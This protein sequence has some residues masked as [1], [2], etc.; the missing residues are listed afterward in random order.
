[1]YDVLQGIRVI[2]LSTWTMVPSGGAVCAEWG[3]DVI[4]IEHPTGDPQRRIRF[5]P[6]WEEPAAKTMTHLPNRGKRSLALDLH[7]AR[8]RDVLLRLVAS[9]DVFLTNFLTPARQK[10]RV[11]VEHL[12]EVNPRLGY[13][14]ATGQG[15]RGPE[16]TIGG[17]DISAGWARPSLAH[18]LLAFGGDEPP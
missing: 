8:G 17:Y 11:D 14:K 13:A 2:E 7:D 16:A 9:A 3:A 18:Q 15:P 10:L 4:K 1:M 12:R 6:T 5:T